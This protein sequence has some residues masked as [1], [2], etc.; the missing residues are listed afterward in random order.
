[1]VGTDIARCSFC[2]GNGAVGSG[3]LD[4]EG[5]G[6][7]VSCGTCAGFGTV[8]LDLGTHIKKCCGIDVYTFA[9][10][11][12][13]SVALGIDKDWNAIVDS[14]RD[15]DALCERLCTTYW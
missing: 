12:R 2:S 13:T 10:A 1:M 6:I 9:H 8:K 14:D 7:K 5:S 11:T 15:I 3:G 4:P